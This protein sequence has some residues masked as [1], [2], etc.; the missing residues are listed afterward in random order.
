MPDLQISPVSIS[1][2]M[3]RRETRLYPYRRGCWQLMA[4]EGGKVTHP[5]GHGRLLLA[6]DGHIP[7]CVWAALTAL[8]E[9]LVTI[10]KEDGEWGLGEAP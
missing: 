3:G 6:T 9:L 1:A 8:R 2:Y 7:M 4:A 10:E 5:L